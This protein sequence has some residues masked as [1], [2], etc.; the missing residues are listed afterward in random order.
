MLIAAVDWDVSVLVGREEEEEE[1]EEGLKKADLN[2]GKT[3]P[4]STSL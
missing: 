4:A 2:F 3:D 1:E